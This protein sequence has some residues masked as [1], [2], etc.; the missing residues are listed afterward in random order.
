MTTTSSLIAALSKTSDFNV[1]TFYLAPVLHI[2]VIS[3]LFTD[4]ERDIRYK[5]VVNFLES[6]GIEQEYLTRILR[7]A[8]IS[9]DL[10]APDEAGPT[11]ALETSAQ[12]TEL[13]SWIPWF[14]D[15]RGPIQKITTVSNTQFVHFYGYKG[16]QGRS[17][18]LAL[19]AK[20]LSNDGFRVLVIDADVEAPSLDYLLGGRADDHSQTLMGLCG[21]ATEIKPIVGVHPGLG[22]GRVD[23]IACR[24][25]QPEVDLDFALFV[26]T[27]PL[28]TRILENGAD[29]LIKFL[30]ES[31]EKYDVVLVDH[32]TGMAASVLPLVKKLPGGAAI[33]ARPD[34]NVV[35]L[36]SD[37][38]KITRSIL[39][40]GF[41]ENSFFVNFSLDP[42]KAKEDSLSPSESIWR[43]ALST[44]LE[45]AT[46]ISSG[47]VDSE[48]IYSPAELSYRWIDW[49]L[50]RALLTSGVPDIARLQID[51]IDSISQ[52]R[53]H[54]N[55]SGQHK[56]Q[57][58]QDVDFNTKIVIQ[59]SV[60][61]ARDQGLFIQI[62]EVEK[63]L[64]PSN[65]YTYILGRK[66]TGKTR[67]LNELVSRNLGQPLL[68]AADETTVGGIQSGSIEA[69][70]WLERCGRNPEVFWW[71]L[72]GMALLDRPK[73]E[74]IKTSIER[75]LRLNTDPKK[76]SDKLSIREETRKHGS[77]IVLLVDGLETMVP[78]AESR[79]LVAALFRLMATVQND[80]AF[81]S[82]LTYRL[83]VREDLASGAVQNVEQQMDG[84]VIQLRWSTASILNF[85]LS[86]LPTLPWIR[87]KF[88]DVCNRITSQ[89]DGERI[90]FGRLSEQEAVDILLEIL[91]DRLRRNN[92]STKTFLKLYF[93]DAGG[94]ATNK[95]A[96]YPRLYMSFLGKLDSLCATDD[97]PLDGDGKIDS[98]L[99]NQ[100]YDGAS[101]DFINETKL[102]LVYLLALQ[103]STA[104]TES[105]EAKVDRFIAAFDSM[106]TPFSYEGAIR[107]LVQ[108]TGFTEECIRASLIRMKSIRMF[109]DRP[110][111]PGWWRVGQLFKMGLR[112]KYT[113]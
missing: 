95:A 34:S 79:E 74:S 37:L 24:S 56:K 32:R 65:P 104:S 33:F 10:V 90:T 39:R 76:L 59:T 31:D 98:R 82:K 103:S 83:F 64:I 107:D 63:L 109:E 41:S 2:A 30:S 18:V 88:P 7:V 70:E 1:R 108:K 57:F 94:D 46:S 91:P 22:N 21:W 12:T 19:M 85:A 96:F 72:L 48:P 5:K 49:F 23:L 111:Y 25:R 27:S 75:H 78:A 106:S 14:D 50:D 36:P 13:S 58:E 97:K 54:L 86:R 105:D 55:L 20:S 16:G 43:E 100:A 67:L 9:L 11:L 101:S 77:P 112:M 113:R 60:S 52:M 71:S 93:S 53:E 8:P 61:G 44:E 51:N 45:T 73:D 62:P 66:G 40:L 69:T 92:L 87:S 81:A 47:A 28:D 3:E 80:S 15:A 42:N 4:L 35:A 89:P 102:E 99:V 38:I 110:G 26:S 68:V 17:T 29:R 84:R 6:Q